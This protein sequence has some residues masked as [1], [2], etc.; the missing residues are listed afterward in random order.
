[1]GFTLLDDMLAP[2]KLCRREKRAQKITTR[3]L[4]DLE[5]KQKADK[6]TLRGMKVNDIDVRRLAMIQDRIP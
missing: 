3:L 2:L 4:G 1:M 6:W 5:M